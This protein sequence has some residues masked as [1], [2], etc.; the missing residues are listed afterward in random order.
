[1][2][3]VFSLCS[4]CSL[5]LLRCHD[6]LLRAHPFNN[7]VLLVLPCFS[8]LSAELSSLLV[9]APAV[10]LYS[11]ARASSLSLSLHLT[12]DSYTLHSNSFS[13]C[14]LVS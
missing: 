7:F 4:L 10:L 13:Y 1:M 3:L 2:R 11:S 5:P 8:V 14:P 12:S 6:D 9:C